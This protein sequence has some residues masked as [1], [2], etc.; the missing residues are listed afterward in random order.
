MSSCCSRGP[1]PRLRRNAR[2]PVALAVAALLRLT[3]RLGCRSFLSCGAFARRA[4]GVAWSAGF[5]RCGQ[6]AFPVGSGYAFGC[7]PN[8]SFHRTPGQ[9]RCLSG[10]ALAGAGEFSRWAV[11]VHSPLATST[12]ALDKSTPCQGAEGKKT[13]GCERLR[14]YLYCFLLPSAWP[15]SFF[16]FPLPGD[17][18]GEVPSRWFALAFSRS[19]ASCPDAIYR[20]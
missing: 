11:N 4:C 14:S 9:R 16:S 19:A 10:G 2:P 17:D 13:G 8:P 18:D 3:R 20:Y 5:L 6:L 1:R 7:S 15:I 12:V